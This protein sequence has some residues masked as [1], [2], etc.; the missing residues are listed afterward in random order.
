MASLLFIVRHGKAEDAP[1]DSTRRLTKEGREQVRQVA[2]HM[3]HA[4]VRVDTIEHSGLL[5]AEETA[6]LFAKALGVTAARGEGL[7][8]DAPPTPLAR[9]LTESRDQ[10]VMIVSHLPLVDRLASSL[11]V[12]D[13]DAEL[14]HFR[15]G[16]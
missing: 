2:A 5:R 15:A 13:E 10:R 7:E 14:L 12:G 3:K 4:K 6:G 9:R 16:T 11:L 1:D 8:A